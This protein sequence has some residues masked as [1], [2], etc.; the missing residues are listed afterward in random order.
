MQK[1]RIWQNL[2]YI[3]VF[4]DDSSFCTKNIWLLAGPSALVS[5]GFTS[6]HLKFVDVHPVHPPKNFH[7]LVMTNSSPWKDPPMLLIGKPSIK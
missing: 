7:P 4:L 2:L 1:C 6:V 5:P 3:R